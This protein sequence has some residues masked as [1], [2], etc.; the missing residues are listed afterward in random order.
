MV[1]PPG[2]GK[3]YKAKQ[4][5]ADNIPCRIHSTDDEFIVDGVYQF[6]PKKLGINHQNCQSKVREAMESGVN[7]IVD[8]T[9]ILKSHR[10]PYVKLAQEFGYEV[11]E[12]FV[13]CD[14]EVAIKRN[15]HNVPEATIRRM[16]ATIE[17]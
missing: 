6:D 11:E 13:E 14:V 17:R 16:A 7:V 9:N 8:N 4:I 2:F 1:A 5:H 15:T 10:A 3:S 12:V